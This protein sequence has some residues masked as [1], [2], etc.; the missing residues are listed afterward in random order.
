M[1]DAVGHHRPFQSER[2]AAFQA[3]LAR[4]GDPQLVDIKRRV[5]ES[6]VAGQGPADAGMAADRFARASVRVALRQLQAVEQSSPA[7]AAWLA[8]HDR[9]DLDEPNDSAGDHPCAA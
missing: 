5:V 3:L 9:V 6:V 7:L 1:R 4:Y 2:H 8:A